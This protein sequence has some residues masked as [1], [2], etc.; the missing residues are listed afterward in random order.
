LRT[1]VGNDARLRLRVLF[2][3][4]LQNDLDVGFCHRL[5]Q[6]PMDNEPAVAVQHA[7]QVVKR[8][9]NIDIAYVDMPMP[10]RLRRLLKTGP[11]LGWLP[12]PFL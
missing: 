11:F 4:Y 3:G 7:A 5:T 6:I 1:I 9:G 8:A 10:M 2:L 12:V